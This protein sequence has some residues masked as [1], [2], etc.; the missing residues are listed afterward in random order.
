VTAGLTTIIMNKK[1]K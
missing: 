1:A